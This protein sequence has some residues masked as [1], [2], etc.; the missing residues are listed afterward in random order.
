MPSAGGTTPRRA[1]LIVG[2][3]AWL[4]AD[5]ITRDALAERAAP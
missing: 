5:G 4:T 3:V 1:G 2:S